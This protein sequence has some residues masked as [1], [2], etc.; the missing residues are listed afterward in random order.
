MARLETNFG[1]NWFQ[2][3]ARNVTR[4]YNEMSLKYIQETDRIYNIPFE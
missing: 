4:M 1:T 3:C 2:G